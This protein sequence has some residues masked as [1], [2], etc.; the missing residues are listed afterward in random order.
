MSEEPDESGNLPSKGLSEVEEAL[1]SGERPSI[2]AEFW[3]FI[4]NEK[5]WWLTPILVVLMLLAALLFATS[6]PLGPFIYP[7]F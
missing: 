4:K 2:L 7:L 3:Y 5:K 1:F 6:T